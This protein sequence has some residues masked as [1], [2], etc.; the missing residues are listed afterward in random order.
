MSKT[1]F[2]AI[3]TTSVGSYIQSNP[4]IVPAGDMG[5]YVLAVDAD[6]DPKSPSHKEYV[7]P[8]YNGIVRVLGS[9]L[10][11][12]LF[13]FTSQQVQSLEELWPL[14]MNHPNRVYVG[15]VVKAQEEGWEHIRTYRADILEGFYKYVQERAKNSQQ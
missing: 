13:A 3:D 4:E 6:F 5:G 11:S 12:D 10:W 2:L 9:L 8:G 15:P 7:S 14:A 1:I